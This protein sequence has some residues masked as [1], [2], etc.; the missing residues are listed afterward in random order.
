M[1]LDVFKIKTLETDVPFTQMPYLHWE[2]N[3]EREAVARLINDEVER[4]RWRRLAAHLEDKERRQEHR[5][6]L[7]GGLTVVD[8]PD[9]HNLEREHRIMTGRN[10]RITNK[11]DVKS[12]ILKSA[13]GSS[14]SSQTAVADQQTQE[15]KG[16]T[17]RRPSHVQGHTNGNR[18]IGWPRR[19]GEL[20]AQHS[21]QSART[22][23]ELLPPEKK[24]HGSTEPGA[25][26][27]LLLKV[28][29][30]HQVMML[31]RDKCL[32]EDYLYNDPPLHPRRTLDQAYNWTLRTTKAR[33]KRQVV[34]RSTH[35]PLKDVHTFDP[36][37]PKSKKPKLWGAA[38]GGKT[39][40]DGECERK[41]SGHWVLTDTVGCEVCRS[42][43]RRTSRLIMVDQLW[44]WVLDENTL[45]TSFPR[46]YGFNKS[47]ISGCHRR[48]RVRFKNARKN[49]IRTIWDMALIVLDECLNTFFYN[50]EPQVSAGCRVKCHSIQGVDR[51]RISNL[52][53][54]TCSLKQSALW[55]VCS[56]S[57]A[58]WPCLICFI[59]CAHTSHSQTN[60]QN[61]LFQHLWDWTERA[62]KAYRARATQISYLLLIDINPESELQREIKGIIDE[63]DI[64]IHIITQQ[65]EVFKRFCKNVER[66]LA[67]NVHAAKLG[68]GG[69]RAGE[70]Q[71]SS[72]SNSGMGLRA[73]LEAIKRLLFREDWPPNLDWFDYQASDI[74]EGFADHIEALEGLKT[75]AQ[76]TAESVSFPAPTSHSRLE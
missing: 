41:W 29:K 70:K 27:P 23:T 62:A 66:I 72:A 49:Q 56:F 55:Y 36:V 13:G 75:S 20:L 32:I 73:E 74:A 47:D 54:W 33:D 46:R 31:Y 60:K 37:D 5:R 59:T 12:L 43:M 2:R 52:K 44:M 1:H 63:L 21:H 17:S 26:G 11:E 8:H 19:K 7:G 40:C 18:P 53:R 22:F 16:S 61:I 48:I 10:S 15:A 58:Q 35:L 65:R 51:C 57:A 68:D 24:Q 3:R 71:R 39:H 6:A 34:Y 76:S 25:L 28:A 14:A 4:Q 69:D 67:P 64:M 30:L 42:N 9:E 45:I 50:V 38:K